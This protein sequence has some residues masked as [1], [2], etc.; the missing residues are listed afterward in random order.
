MRELQPSQLARL[1]QIDYDR[2]I[3]LIATRSNQSGVAET[4]GVVRAVGDPDNEQAEFAITIRSDL[5]G[6]GLGTLLMTKLIADCRRRKTQELIG[7]VLTENLAMRAL[8]RKFGFENKSVEGEAM[9]LLRFRLD[10]S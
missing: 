9:S 6:Q 4:L 10:Q 2:E 8:A 3:A 7:Y 5:K 1:T